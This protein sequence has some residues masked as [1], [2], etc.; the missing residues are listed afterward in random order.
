MKSFLKFILIVCIFTVG[1]FYGYKKLALDVDGDCA[2][3]RLVHTEEYGFCLLISYYPQYLSGDTKGVAVTNIPFFAL[4]TEKVRDDRFG[5]DENLLA[6]NLDAEILGRLFSA[7]FFGMDFDTKLLQTDGVSV[8]KYGKY[9]VIS[10]KELA[11]ESPVPPIKG[12]SNERG[13]MEW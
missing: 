5:L 9:L 3:R 10:A 7:L 1:G 4:F 2:T 12:T 13:G 8:G 11:Y 6:K